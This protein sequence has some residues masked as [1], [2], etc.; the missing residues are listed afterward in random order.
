MSAITEDIYSVHRRIMAA[1]K[2]GALPKTIKLL[3]E[4][5]NTRRKVSRSDGNKRRCFWLFESGGTR[6]GTLTTNKQR[7][8]YHQKNLEIM[9]CPMWIFAKVTYNSLITH[10]GVIR[11][12]TGSLSL[13]KKIVNVHAIFYTRCLLIKYYSSLSIHS[14]GLCANRTELTTCALLLLELSTI[15]LFLDKQPCVFS[16]RTE[17]VCIHP[18]V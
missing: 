7:E 13:Y 8:L 14:T 12:K 4:R 16:Q 6:V 15:T 10:T 5:T 17:S 18:N 9:T 3:K 1:Q 11:I 2:Y